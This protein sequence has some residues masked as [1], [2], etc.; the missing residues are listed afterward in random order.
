MFHYLFSRF[1]KGK[2]SV[3]TDVKELNKEH[4]YLFTTTPLGTIIHLTVGNFKR[5]AFL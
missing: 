3:F 2:A 4:M 5:H 1:S